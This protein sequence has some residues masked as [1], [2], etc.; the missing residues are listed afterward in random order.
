MIWNFFPSLYIQKQPSRGVLWKRCSENMKQIYKRKPMPKCDFNKVAFL[1]IFRTL[2]SKNTFGW[3]L[4]YI[5]FRD[6]FSWKNFDNW[7]HHQNAIFIK[8]ILSLGVTCIDEAGGYI[9]RDKQIKLLK[10]WEKEWNMFF[11][12]KLENLAYTGQHTK[13]QAKRLSII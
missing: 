6:H 2:F 13:Y 11:L 8:I 4:L 3:L 5:F 10:L 12:I 9:L 7:S 1:H